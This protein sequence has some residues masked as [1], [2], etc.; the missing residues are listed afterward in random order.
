[1][2]VAAG[3]VRH[4]VRQDTRNS[5]RQLIKDSGALD[6]REDGV[7]LEFC[8][9]REGTLCNFSED[10]LWVLEVVEPIGDLSLLGL[11]RDLAAARVFGARGWG[12]APPLWM[13]VCLYLLFFC[14]VLISQGK[15]IFCD[16]YLP[17]A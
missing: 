17:F 2:Y 16:E 3:L 12:G 11:C 4:I 10:A 8:A 9:V 6:E 1:M 13:P 7:L 15:S 14:I 5:L